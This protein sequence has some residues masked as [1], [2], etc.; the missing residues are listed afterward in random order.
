MIKM[1]GNYT[2]RLVG[3]KYRII[4]DIFINPT[5]N[6]T[7]VYQGNNFLIGGQSKLSFVMDIVNKT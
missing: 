1:T 3:L 2:Y 5:Y 7:I 4:E 6:G